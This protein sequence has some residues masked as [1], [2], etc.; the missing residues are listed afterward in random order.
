MGPHLVAAGS[1]H[2]TLGESQGCRGEAVA[3]L[4]AER[5]ALV[6]EVGG[7]VPPSCRDAACA[8][9][10]RRRHR[11][12]HGPAV[13]PGVQHPP[14]W[15]AALL[16][17]V[18]GETERGDTGDAEGVGFR[19]QAPDRRVERGRLPAGHAGRIGEHDRPHAQRRPVRGIN[20]VRGGVGRT[21]GAPARH[22]GRGVGTGGEPGPSPRCGQLAQGQRVPRAVDQDRADEVLGQAGDVFPDQAAG[23]SIRERKDRQPGEPGDGDGPVVAGPRGREEPD[24]AARQPPSNERQRGG[25]LVVEVLE[26]VDHDQ[27]RSLPTEASQER[28]RRRADQQAIRRRQS[29]RPDRRAKGLAAAAVEPVQR[30]THRPHETGKIAEGDAGR[31][32]AAHAEDRCPAGAGPVRRRGEQRG[33][34]HA[35][36]TREHQGTT[37]CRGVVEER[38]EDIPLSRASDQIATAGRPGR[39]GAGRDGLHCLRGA[40]RHAFVVVGVRMAPRVVHNRGTRR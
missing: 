26:V 22:V 36:L 38:V 2:Q 29:G 35:G 8:E 9:Q 20:A 23:V 5:A 3:V 37:P 15:R 1:G 31:G 10:R 27:V 21:G 6:G 19:G 24:V 32:V 14:Q 25:A 33:L 18:E 12:R 40:H 11:G 34:A 7:L 4:L 13:T 39:R 17:P 16:D 28:H 30:V